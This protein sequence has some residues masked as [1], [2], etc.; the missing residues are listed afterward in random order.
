VSNTPYKLRELKRLPVYGGSLVL[1][2]PCDSREPT[3]NNLAF[4]H[5]SGHVIWYA[6][7]PQSHDCYVEFEIRAASLMAWTFGGYRVELNAKTGGILR[8]TFTK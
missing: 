3:P 6:E 1:F 2:D 4:V 7:L 8:S 5:Q